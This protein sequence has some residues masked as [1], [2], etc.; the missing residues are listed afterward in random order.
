[1]LDRQ[2]DIDAVMI[3][4]PDHSHAVIAM[5]AMRQGKHIYVQKPLAHDVAEV[6]AITEAARKYKVATQMGNQ[7][8]SC[9]DMRLICE[10]IAAG[11]LG[12]VREVHA[13]TNRPFWPQSIEA[14]RPKETPPIPAG[15]DW[16]LWIGPAAMRPVPSGVSARQRG[17]RGGTSAPVRWATWAATSSMPPSGP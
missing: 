4:T 2:R 15:L 14:E 9:G 1:M 11:A 5:A 12:A 10:W 13:W 3:A 17:G 8:H 6:R 7:G 16:D